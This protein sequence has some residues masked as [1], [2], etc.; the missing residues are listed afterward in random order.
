[1]APYT[2]HPQY[3]EEY[4]WKG[5]SAQDNT[6]EPRQSLATCPKLFKAFLMTIPATEKIKPVVVLEVETIL[7]RRK[8]KKAG[9]SKDVRKSLF[10]LD[11]S[12]FPPF[13]HVLPAHLIFVLFYFLFPPGSFFILQRGSS[14]RLNGKG[15][16]PKITPG[17]QGNS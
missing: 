17:S 2:W 3:T 8:E 13:N 11:I 14:T 16:L 12:P 5:F 1:M 10:L 9:H 4:K 15:F 7:R 6:W